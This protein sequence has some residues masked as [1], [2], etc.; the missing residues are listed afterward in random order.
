MIKQPLEAKT[1]ILSAHE[2]YACEQMTTVPGAVYPEHHIRVLR[3]EDVSNGFLSLEPCCGTH[4]RSTS[5]LENF[6]ITSIR[7]TKSGTFE[8]TAV[9]GRRAQ[10]V[11]ENGTAMLQ[12][13]SEIR[14]KTDTENTE[15]E[16]RELI[17]IVKRA[18][19]NLRN[20]D[21]PFTIKESAF[22]ELE[23]I[24]KRVN[25]KLRESIR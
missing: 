18:K 1:V 5:E 21:L 22:K 11:Y 16:L 23:T 24:D 14:T 12:T 4:V 15:K 20:N 6:C 9:C 8:F 7:S 25:L 3:I 19:S 10:I 2:L 13:L 17:A